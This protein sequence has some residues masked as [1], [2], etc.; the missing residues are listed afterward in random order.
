MPWATATAATPRVRAQN[1]PTAATP[2]SFPPPFTG[3]KQLNLSTYLG[4]GRDRELYTDSLQA[5]DAHTQAPIDSWCGS[6]LSTVVS[7][8]LFGIQLTSGVTSRERLSN[9]HLRLR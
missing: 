2:I 8:A 6:A 3:N 7:P 5:Q 9:E 4:R 1:L